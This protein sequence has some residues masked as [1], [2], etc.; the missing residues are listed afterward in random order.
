MEILKYMSQII[1]VVGIFNVWLVRFNKQTQYRGGESKS[2]EEE[3]RVYGYPQWFFY[4][5]GGLKI[6]FAL[7]I[8]AGFWVENVIKIGA[9][10]MSILMLGAIFSHLKVKDSVSKCVPATIMLGLSLFIFMSS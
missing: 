7:C 8:G 6:L 4:L 10:G 3:F 2:L 1:I 9:S 5:I